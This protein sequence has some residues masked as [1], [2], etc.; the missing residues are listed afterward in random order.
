MLRLHSHSPTPVTLRIH[1]AALDQVGTIL[2]RLWVAE[3]DCL[4]AEH[5]R[6]LCKL[7]RL[8]AAYNEVVAELRDL[9]PEHA[10]CLECLETAREWVRFEQDRPTDID[11]SPEAHVETAELECR[12]NGEYTY[13]QLAMDA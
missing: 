10:C 1:R 13:H 4:T 2:G 3:S 7:E 8:E 12:A 6:Y 5:Q 11:M 9:H